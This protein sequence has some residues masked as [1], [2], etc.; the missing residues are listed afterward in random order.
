MRSEHPLHARAERLISAAR[1]VLAAGSLIAV[2]LEP[3]EPARFARVAYSILAIYSVYALLLVAISWRPVP[4]GWSRLTHAIDMGVF[5]TVVFLTRWSASPFFAYF[6]FA[7]LVATMRWSWQGAAPTLAILVLVY[8]ALGPYEV[9]VAADPN[10][11][12]NRF[13]VRAVYLVVVG[14]LIAYVGYYQRVRQRQFALLAEWPTQPAANLEVLLAGVLDRAR[15]ILGAARVVLAVEDAGEPWL[16]VAICGPEG[17]QMRREPPQAGGLV[18]D[19]LASHHFFCADVRAGVC[20]VMD[21]DRREVRTWR[22]GPLVPGAAERLRARRVAGWRVDQGDR[23]CRLL[24]LDGPELGADDLVLGD[25]VAKGIVSRLEQ[26][27]LV[28][29]LERAA[30][31]DERLR[32][33]RNLH[34]GVLQSLTGVALRLQS[35]RRLLPYDS[36]A[37]E[38]SLEELQ[39]LVAAEHYEL[40]S[41][42]HQLRPDALPPPRP[43]VPIAG[44]LR[45]VVARVERQWG[46][47]IRLA[48]DPEDVALPRELFEEVLLLAQEALVNAV[49]HARPTRVDIT[50]QQQPTC[51]VLSVSDDGRGF[52]FAG[53]LNLA[54]LA[55]RDIGPRTLRERVAA[56]EGDLAIDSST[57]GAKVRVSI[58]LGRAVA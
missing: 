20:L 31:T 21:T 38:R 25:V 9:F 47:A 32:L 46:V 53:R 14:S 26:H 1:L 24:A 17:L 55:D 48:L 51:L 13:V 40:R 30:I 15:C 19:A 45:D 37:A 2:W 12:L 27:E 7:I 3:S 44:R 28:R 41:V 50:L 56:L 57:T 22:G 52:P 54:E 18:V 16:D 29:E 33:A 36:V 8:L 11:E 49:R 4:S 42:I 23:S 6:V 34:D 5:I 10:F 58:P 35:A 39:R 43:D